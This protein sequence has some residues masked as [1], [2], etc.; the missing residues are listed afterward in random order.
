MGFWSWCGDA[1]TLAI[2]E[3][4]SKFL[5]AAT[6]IADATSKVAI[7]ISGFSG[8]AMEHPRCFTVIAVSSVVCMTVVAV[9]A[10]CRGCV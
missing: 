10:I 2:K 7:A 8:F 6:K 3:A 4:A 1:L 9:T 5:I